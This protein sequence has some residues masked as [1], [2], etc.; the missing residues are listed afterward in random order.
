VP[1][2]SARPPAAPALV[3]PLEGVRVLEVAR[4][5][6]GPYAGWVLAELG[7]E[8]IKVED[9]GRPDDARSVGPYFVGEQSLYFAALNG[10]KRSLALRLLDPEGRALFLELA[11]TADVVLDN[12]KPGVMD[13]LGLG[14]DVLH[15]VN[16]A[17]ITCSLSGFGATGALRDRAGYDYTVQAL[18]GVM[19]MTGEPDTA[20]G[21]AGISYVDH[22]GGLA[23][24]LAISAALAG[25]ART[26]TGGHLDLALFDVQVSMLSY[27]AAWQLNAGYVGE[28]T[29][30]AAHPSLVPAQNFGTA[31]GYISLFVGNDAMWVRLTEALGDPWLADPRLARNQARQQEREAVLDRLQQLLVTAPSQH[32]VDLFE[33]FHVPCAP[34][35]DLGQALHNQQVSDRGLVGTAT[36][37]DYGSY[38]HV[39]GPFPL[40]SR[41]ESVPAP[42]LG[43]H[44]LEVLREAGVGAERVAELV[45]QG[46]VMA[47]PARAAASVA[48][49]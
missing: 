39:R 49:P 21:K 28:R 3:T 45:R 36:H 6:A 13:K 18:A 32:W 19:S 37:G 8:V 23:A 33:R 43:E 9:C 38:Q 15:E 29:S 41:A 4:L 30:S 24:A 42:A 25:R 11:K 22:S 40:A 27:L 47:G 34:V 44:S 35:N 1:E 7:A 10:G 12:Q 16:P 2:G 26:G 14:P 48:Q 5:L 46:V 17:L 20:P 31:D